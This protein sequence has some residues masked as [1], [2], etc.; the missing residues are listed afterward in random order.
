MMKKN[1]Y[2]YMLLAM[3]VLLAACEPKVDDFNPSKG[4]ADFT[5]FIAIGDSYTA[6]YTDGALGLRGQQESFSYILG[7]QLMYVGNESYHQPLVQAEGSVGTTV[8]DAQGT[9][10]GYFELKVTER[11]LSPVPSVGNVA[12]LAEDAYDEDNQ[13][14]GVPGAKVT[15]L[16]AAG[17]AQAN[18]F[19]A[20]FASSDVTHVLGDAATANPTFFSCWL[21]GNDVLSFALAGG[22]GGIGNGVTD[23]TD[24]ATFE[25]ALAA[26]LNTLTAKGAKGVVGNIPDVS[27]IPFFTTVPYNAFV[28]DAATA[29]ALNAKYADYNA[30][31]ESVGL[32]QMVFA[33]GP[34][35]FVIYDESIPAQLGHRRQATAED[36]LLLTA[37]SEALSW[38]PT[39]DPILGN[40]FVLTKD[41]LSMISTA[42]NQ[43]NAISKELADG[44]GLAFFDANALMKE[45]STKGII[46]DGHHYT[47]TFVTGGIFSLDGI[48]ATGRGSAIIANAM[49]DAINDTYGS[50]VPRANINDYDMVKFP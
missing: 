11:G 30:A 50:T 24:A 25:S 43:F 45:L 26:V 6:G 47:G 36:R 20:R 17:Y 34:N 33:E 39:S 18:P 32:P 9:L 49:I 12:I 2:Q 37:Q 46:I 16:V 4:T 19:F 48:H 44:F 5:K 27:S 42:T 38:G 35:A 8:I 1:I 7:Q 29:A 28:I 40:E 10:N 13:N 31:A 15:H 14:F 23:I 21:A 41:E 3:V 22:V